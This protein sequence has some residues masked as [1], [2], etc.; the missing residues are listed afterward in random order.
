VE[1]IEDP[2][3]PSIIDDRLDAIIVRYVHLHN[4][5]SGM[6]AIDNYAIFVHSC[7]RFCQKGKSNTFTNCKT[8]LKTPETYHYCTYIF[9]GQYRL[10]NELY[11]AQLLM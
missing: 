11:R 6:L 1:P 7:M 10:Q 9:T 2:Y 4:R 8:V 5:F 3:G